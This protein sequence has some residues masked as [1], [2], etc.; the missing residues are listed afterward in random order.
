MGT[1]PGDGMK[2]S[3]VNVGGGGIPSSALASEPRAQEG[4]QRPVI[5]TAV[6][7]GPSTSIICYSRYIMIVMQP[8]S[9]SISMRHMLMCASHAHLCTLA[10]M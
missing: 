3:T 7:C 5:C 8:A 9:L 6:W 1:W 10:C 4:A 2:C